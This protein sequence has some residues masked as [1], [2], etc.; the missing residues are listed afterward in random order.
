MKA[1]RLEPNMT[2]SPAAPS[3]TARRESTLAVDPSDRFLPI[4]AQRPKSRF[5]PVVI[6]LVVAA[7]IGGAA[8]WWLRGNETMVSLPTSTV[9]PAMTPTG[10]NG[11]QAVGTPATPA[12]S[13]ESKP[14]VATAVPAPV[15]QAETP[16][17]PVPAQAAPT[18]S[19]TVPAPASAQVP[20]QQAATPP[21]EAVEKPA[22]ATSVVPEKAPEKK[23]TEKK[24]IAASEKK[25][26]PATAQATSQSK[27]AVKKATKD[28]GDKS[29][30]TL[31]NSLTNEAPQQEAV[32]ATQEAGNE[33]PA[34]EQPARS[35]PSGQT[36]SSGAP[37]PVTTAPST[38]GSQLFTP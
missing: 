27:P 5:M 21:A 20:V 9:K 19:A 29:F 13:A 28:E 18:V 38:P 16:T 26:K 35:Q 31:L 14:P 12:I 23:P 22:K 30:S 15:Q 4:D 7:S 37:L 2:L 11:P 24:A 10:A 33:Q 17:Q 3:P 8:V 34:T 25:S 1:S 32:P 36:G 6:G